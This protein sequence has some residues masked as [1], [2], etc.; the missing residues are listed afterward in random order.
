MK[1]IILIENDEVVNVT[2]RKILTKKDIEKMSLEDL[3]FEIDRPKRE[4][5]Q[6]LDSVS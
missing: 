4:Y 1:K 5:F 2:S 6:E 3:I